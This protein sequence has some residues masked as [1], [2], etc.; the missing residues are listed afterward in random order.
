M[1]GDDLKEIMD[2]YGATKIFADL[3]DSYNIP[4]TFLPGN[5][6]GEIDLAEYILQEILINCNMKG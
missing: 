6:D 1:S 5:N 4:W 3:V 2:K